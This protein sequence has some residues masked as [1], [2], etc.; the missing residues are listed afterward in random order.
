MQFGSPQWLYA[1]WL[2]PMM[3]ALFHVS[4]RRRRAALERFADRHLLDTVA[5]GARTRPRY[6]RPSAL[7]A[8]VA[9]LIVAL[10]QPK[11]GYH[12]EE[13]RRR[14]VDIVVAI[15]TSKSMLAEDLAP[16]RLGRAWP[17][18]RSR[19]PI[20]PASRSGPFHPKQAHTSPHL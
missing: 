6:R 19:C 13:V 4:D 3:A 10:S 7:M 15:D 8:A 2:V 16:N 17:P 20:E 5:P 9:L 11:W 1:L 14:G 18:C 12:W